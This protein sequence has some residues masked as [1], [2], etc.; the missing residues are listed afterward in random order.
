MHIR[1][2]GFTASF[3]ALVTFANAAHAETEFEGALCFTSASAACHA[4]GW[5]TGCFGARYAPRD[6]GD[7]GPDT[8][9]SLFARTFAVGFMLPSGNPVS[10]TL[11]NV[12]MSKVA[13]GGYTH[14]V[15]F[16][17]KAQTP[18]AP[19]PSTQNITFRGVF[20]NWDEIAGCTMEFNSALTKKP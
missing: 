10:P 5:S 9:L 14:P 4:E 15:K 11:Y 8:E 16:R 17:L 3:I 19:T 7:N 20:A 12:T 18:S 13:R 2:L 6:L 1:A